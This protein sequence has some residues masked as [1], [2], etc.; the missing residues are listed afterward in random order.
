MGQTTL[1]CMNCTIT[2][3]TNLYNYNM[4]FIQNWSL[5]LYVKSYVY[6]NMSMVYIKQRF[7]WIKYPAFSV[8]WVWAQVGTYTS[9]INTKVQY[10]SCIGGISNTYIYNIIYIYR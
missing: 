10:T 7:S 2:V 8:H 6:G 3:Y 4:L 9:N 1:S 5:L